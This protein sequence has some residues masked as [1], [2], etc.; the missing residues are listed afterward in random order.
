MKSCNMNLYITR[1][2]RDK[3]GKLIKR[4]RRRQ[5]KSF[6]KQWMQLLEA[7][8][9]HA[10]GANADAVT[11]KDTGNTN[12]SVFA[13]VTDSYYWLAAEAPANT[14]TYGTQIGT[15]TTAPT[16][17]DYSMETQIAHGVGAGQMQY[18][19][20]SVQSAAVNGASMEMNITRAFVNGSGGAITVREVGLV[21]DTIGF[22]F[23][24][25]RDAVNDTVNDGQTYT[26]TYTLQ[27]TV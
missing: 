3:N 15:G 12:R 25:L 1:E 7:I 24:V 17:A 27:T 9:A 18:G 26:V 6:V 4:W 22:M 16:T 2:I 20:C 11:I 21:V 14:S 19:A 23:L 8:M 5:S 10:Y 13:Q